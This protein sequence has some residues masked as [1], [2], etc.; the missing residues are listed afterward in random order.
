M[1]FRLRAGGRA[2]G[3]HRRARGPRAGRR[4][5]LESADRRASVCVGHPDQRPFGVL[6]L[7][8]GHNRRIGFGLLVRLCASDG[9]PAKRRRPG[10]LLQRS[11][12]WDHAGVRGRERV[13]LPSGLG[14]HGARGVGAGELRTRKG[15]DAAGGNGVSDHVPRR[16][17]VA[18]GGLPYPGAGGGRK[19]RFRRL[20]PRRF[21]AST[22]GTRRGIS[23]VLFRVRS[24]G[25]S[26][27]AAC[28]APGGPSRGAQQ[29]LRADVR[30]RHQD[31]YLR[32]GAGVLR[33]L[34]HAAGLGGNPGAERGRTLG[35]AG[36]TV[37]ADG[38]RFEAPTGVPQHREHR[39]HSDRVRRGRGL[40]GAGASDAG[41]AWR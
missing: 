36:R 13:L 3:D 39:H 37:R 26:D 1:G 27:P 17:R 38:A 21:D 40:P 35:A 28:L 20:S 23:A 30:H 10:L 33:F 5:H 31:R 2:A 18:V 15:A 41:G 34:R 22:V 14:D 19:P 32:D 24:E 8:A 25:R 7:D 6:H 9:R 16:L 4:D 12:A 29:H 11:P